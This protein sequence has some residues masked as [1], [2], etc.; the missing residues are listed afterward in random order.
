MAHTASVPYPMT[1]APWHPTSTSTVPGAGCTGSSESQPACL[2]FPLQSH[3]QSAGPRG[4]SCRGRAR[5]SPLE[6][7]TYLRGA[8]GL[9]THQHAHQPRVSSRVWWEVSQPVSSCTLSRHLS[10]KGFPRAATQAC[11]SSQ[12]SPLASVTLMSHLPSAYLMEGTMAVPTQK[13][14]RVYSHNLN[15]QQYPKE[16]EVTGMGL[17][18][19]EWAAK[20]TTCPGLSMI[21]VCVDIL[22]GQRGF[23][24]TQSH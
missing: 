21:G 10:K 17:G 12:H 8:C 11:Y 4:D 16:K 23:L 1:V 5:L 3:F 22:G 20:S 18:Y 19:G 15:T 7:W 14:T 9:E 2:L 6:M 13:G 24:S